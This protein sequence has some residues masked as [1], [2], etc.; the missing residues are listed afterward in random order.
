MGEAF[1]GNIG[2]RAVYDFTAIGDVV[3]TAARLQGKARGGEVL[4][5]ERVASGLPA[6]VGTPV[7]LELKGKRTLSAHI[8]SRCNRAAA[9]MFNQRLC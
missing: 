1:V 8:G 4:L 3:N 2:E 7:E 9:L 6:A 5:S